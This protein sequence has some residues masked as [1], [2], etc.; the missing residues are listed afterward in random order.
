MNLN[1]LAQLISEKEGGTENLSIAQIKEVIA[2]YH[3]VLAD[4]LDT[5]DLMAHLTKMVNNGFKRLKKK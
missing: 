4:N 1:Q 5:V 3:E 2:C